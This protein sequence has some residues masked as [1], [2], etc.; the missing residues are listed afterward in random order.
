MITTNKKSTKNELSTLLR[1]TNDN[2]LHII[3]PITNK[4]LSDLVTTLKK[5][6][7]D[8]SYI[9]VVVIKNQ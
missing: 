7:N 1:K 3:S 8:S 5:L 4:T 6:F 2:Q 9:T